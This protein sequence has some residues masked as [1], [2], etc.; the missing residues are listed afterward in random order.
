M[1]HYLNLPV[2]VR[3]RFKVFKCTVRY[4]HVYNRLDLQQA[5]DSIDKQVLIEKLSTFGIRD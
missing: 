5:L 3:Y 2:R 4:N 1:K